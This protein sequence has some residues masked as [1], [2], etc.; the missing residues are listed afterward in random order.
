MVAAIT[1]YRAADGKEFDTKEAAADYEARGQF[2]VLT[3][4]SE[5]DIDAVLAGDESARHIA[6]A[7]EV[8]GSKIAR[9]RLKAGD[10]K[11]ERKP[12]SLTAV[13]NPPVPQAAE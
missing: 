13:V 9:R 1:K 7:I 8:L 3:D 2:S 6:D 5:A 4:L 10:K 11:R 12:A